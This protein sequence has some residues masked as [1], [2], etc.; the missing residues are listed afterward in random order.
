MKVVIMAGGKGTRI[1][2]IAQDVPKPM[3]LIQNKPI[4]Q[5]EIES[6]REQGFTEF[7]ITISYLGQIIKNYFDDG[8]RFGVHI[9]YY[10]EEEPLGTAGA[11]FRIRDKLT[12][13][14]LLINADSIFD[15]D[16]KRFV[17]FHKDQGGLVTL[18]THPNSHPYDSGLLVVDQDNYVLNWM[19][20]EETRPKYY[21]N[22]V[23]AGIHIVNP[24]VLDQ[25][26]STKKVDLDRQLLKPLCGE[27]KMV[28]YRSPEY[29]RDMGTPERYYMVCDDF[30]RGIIKSKNLLQKQKAIF[31]DRDGTINEY[32]GFLRNI[33][34]F[35]LKN[36]V[37]SAIKKINWSQYL[38]IVVTNQPVIARGEVTLEGLDYIHKKMETELGKQGAFLDATFFCPHHPDKG[39]VGE[40]LEY[41]VECN[42]RKPK[43]GMLLH[44][45]KKYN[46]DLKQ[47]W[48]IGDGKNDILA[49]KKAGCKTCLI[50]ENSYGQDYTAVSLT[51]AVDYILLDKN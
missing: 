5:Y 18:F 50:G 25:K 41:K 27:K 1:A 31:L 51:Q 48:M 23:N 6:L 3:I 4:L 28:S 20:K 26:I 33:E 37:A 42:C 29:V 45:A 14:F 32:V 8:K 21:R 30:K 7:I 24:C 34:K 47:S 13:D 36:D 49:G 22:L 35:V 10:F 15:I 44:A 46:I 43:P 19:S 2:S 17:K 12:E 38:A 9:E 40:L 39:F 11:L 16:F